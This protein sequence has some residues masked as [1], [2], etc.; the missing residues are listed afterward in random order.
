MPT[1]QRM[2]F[3][4]ALYD[5]ALGFEG[6]PLVGCSAFGVGPELTRDGHSFFVRAFDFEVNE[7]FDRDKAVFF[8]RGEGIPF[9]SVAWPG[10][11]GVVTGM[12]L[13][14]V[15]VAVNGARAGEPRAEG[16]PVAFALR[17]VLER[18]H[19]T[20]EAVAIL[21]EQLVMVSHLVLVGDAAGDFAVVER[22]PGEVAYVRWI[23]GGRIGVTNHLEGPLQN[24]PK[25]RAVLAR[26]TTWARRRRLD[27]LLA[28]L[29]PGEVDAARAL[30]ILRDHRCA[31]QEECPLGDRRSLDALIATHGVVADTTARILWVG[32]GPHLSGRFVGLDLA[33]VFRGDREDVGMLAEDPMVAGR[34]GPRP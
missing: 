11:V 1:Y 34:P 26:T 7:V 12:N 27:E 33:R 14:G 19:D 23:R 25:N 16:I 24:D 4:H 2:V 28:A 15:A 29:G 31:G 9:A 22:V 5:I 30:A 32:A 13:E 21:S 10:F 20:R 17:E 18:A 8:V 3:L 6:S